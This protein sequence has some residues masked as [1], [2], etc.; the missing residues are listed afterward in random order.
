[1]NAKQAEK[2]ALDSQQT[3]LK[4]IIYLLLERTKA[5][6]EAGAMGV[7]VGFQTQYPVV[8]VEGAV[9]H[10]KELGYECSLVKPG[11]SVFPNGSVHIRWGK[12]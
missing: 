11:S 3:L 10:L 6:A 9:G 1:M 5:A 8:C 7:T 12:P 2:L 4:Q